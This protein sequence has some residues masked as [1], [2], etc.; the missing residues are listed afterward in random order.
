MRVRA[1]L[2]GAVVFAATMG[3]FE[4]SVVV[5][6]RRLWELGEIDVASAPLSN[7]LVLTELLREIA[8][9]GMIA[10]VAYL[11]GRRGVER[12]AQAAD[13]RHLGHSITSTCGC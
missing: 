10:S 11:A 4:A 13:L 12:F 2:A 1:R 6:L 3:F 7:R 5:Y 9:L 8:S